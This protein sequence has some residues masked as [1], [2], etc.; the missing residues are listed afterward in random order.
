MPSGPVPHRL[1]GLFLTLCAVAC[2]PA[3]EEL[4][5]AG[6]SSLP[7]AAPDT[8]GPPPPDLLGPLW[9]NPGSKSVL[10][11]TSDV[12]ED[13]V[14]GV[15]D[16]RHL[17]RNID[18]GKDDDGNRSYVTLEKGKRTGDFTVGFSGGPEGTVTEVE[19]HYRAKR[20]DSRGKVLAELFDGT[21]KL[22]RG[23]VNTLQND[24][25]D[26][27]DRFSGLSVSSADN[28]RVRL[29][30]ETT[31][32]RGGL[33][34]TSLWLKV[35]AEEPPPTGELRVDVFLLKDISTCVIGNVCVTEPCLFLADDSGTPRVR[36]A[37][38]GAFRGVT[39][40][41]PAVETAP[42][43][44]CLRLRMTDAQVAARRAELER[45]RDDVALWTNGDLMLDLRFHEMDATPL[46]LSRFGGGLWV[47][48]WDLR[49]VGFPLLSTETD[50]TLVTPG[51]R[52]PD[53]GLHHEL[54]GCGG[55]FGADLGLAGAGHSWVPD[56][57]GAFS[58]QCADHGVY[59]HEWL[60]QLHFDVHVLSHFD[61][62]YDGNYP[63]CGMG[64]PDTRLWFPDTHECN[65]D[66]DA[67]FC[68]AVQ[69]GTNDE[70]NEHVLRAHWPPRGLRLITNHCRN[71]IQDYDETGVDIGPNCPG[72]L[73]APAA[74]ASPA[75]PPVPRA[76]PLPARR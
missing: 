20:H 67:P 38:D 6:D 45:Y 70:V 10:V 58:F 39:P 33:R 40:D 35:K 50:F 68:G 36:F 44:Q 5:A 30:F 57:E 18:E 65:R 37:D 49:P 27:K 22:G 28:L 21:R 24:W 8:N 61:D 41:D 4:D 1:L 53:T 71:G 73:R 64:A 59:T 74:V 9:K 25:K 55:T 63:A 62:L 48:P 52:D 34:V 2:G 66:P 29:S 3:V 14:T 12:D 42:V 56:T 60:H 51:V 72:T 7:A 31:S 15:P 47:A 26:F 13:D 69:C 19:V 43:V 54:G 23:R 76:E 17:Y 46:S 75:S 32:G 16:R 11:P